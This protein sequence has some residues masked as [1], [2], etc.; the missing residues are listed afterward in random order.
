MTRSRG[1]R[2]GARARY[3][4]SVHRLRALLVLSLPLGVILACGPRERPA[5][6]PIAPTGTAPTA[7]AT[8]TAPPTT[9]TATSPTTTTTTTPTTIA[10]FPIPGF[11]VAGLPASPRAAIVGKWDV[12]G[13]D[14]KPIATQPG[15]ATDPLDPATYAAGSNVT[16][17]NDTVTLARGP[18][19]I[20]SRPYKVLGEQPPLRVTIDAGNGA[21]DVTFNVDGSVFWSLPATP[22]H[23]LTLTRSN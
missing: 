4:R 20:L 6:E 12:V 22:P 9:A 1:A 17:T 13:V 2:V 3:A 5:D 21:S 11:K 23:V 16:F 14:G 7:T 19:T 15:M 18:A 8:A 10:G